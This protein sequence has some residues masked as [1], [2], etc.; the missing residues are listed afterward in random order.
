MTYTIL[1]RCQDLLYRVRNET[2]VFLFDIFEDYK[3]FARE[4]GEQLTSAHVEMLCYLFG[5]TPWKTENILNHRLPGYCFLMKTKEIQEDIVYLTDGLNTIG[6]TLRG[7]IIEHIYHSHCG[8]QDEDVTY[9]EKYILEVYSFKY[10]CTPFVS[11]FNS[12]EM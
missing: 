6:L 10:A 4:A 8:C 7:L 11:D 3:L 5:K 1:Q 9:G 12:G 2:L